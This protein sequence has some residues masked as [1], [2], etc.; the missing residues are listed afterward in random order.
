M[1]RKLQIAEPVL[2][3]EL[4]G[5]DAFGVDVKQIGRLDAVPV[6]V[7]PPIARARIMQP[8]FWPSGQSSPF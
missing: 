5:T 8:R 2:L 6:H 1:A 4:I 7:P 3:G